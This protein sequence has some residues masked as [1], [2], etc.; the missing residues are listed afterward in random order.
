MIYGWGEGFLK[1]LSYRVKNILKATRLTVRKI[2]IEFQHHHR[3]HHHHHLS[4][5]VPNFHHAIAYVTL[6]YVALASGS[7][8][9]HSTLFRGDIRWSITRPQEQHQSYLSYLSDECH[10]H[11]FTCWNALAWRAQWAH[12]NG[13]RKVTLVGRDEKRRVPASER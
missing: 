12:S 10:L 13:W 2:E 7:H 11:A 1:Q 3:H 6:C 4:A 5:S 8:S 9:N